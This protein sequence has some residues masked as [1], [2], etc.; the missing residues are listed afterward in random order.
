MGQEVSQIQINRNMK[1]LNERI[2]RL[3]AELDA[4]AAALKKAKFSGLERG[5]KDL[6]EG[7]VHRYKSVEAL[8]K[9]VWG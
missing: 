2:D 1:Q 8:A 3:E 6:K 5:L 9:G 7:R 4:I